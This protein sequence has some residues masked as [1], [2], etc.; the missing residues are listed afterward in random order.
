VVFL[1]KTCSRNSQTILHRGAYVDLDLCECPI[2]IGVCRAHSRSPE[3]RYVLLVDHATPAS[4]F[5]GSDIVTLTKVL[6]VVRLDLTLVEST[7]GPL[8]QK[9]SGLDVFE[10]IVQLYG[11]VRPLIPYHIHT[12]FV[13]IYDHITFAFYLSTRFDRALSP[14]TL[15]SHPLLPTISFQC[16]AFS[17]NLVHLPR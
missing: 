5:D 12:R 11:T 2:L 1:R 3:R 16:A 17:P 7:F 13:S 14:W 4:E 8:Y 15:A 10:E 9:M 6:T